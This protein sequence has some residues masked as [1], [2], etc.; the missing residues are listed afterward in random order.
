[1]YFIVNIMS[2]CNIKRSVVTDGQESAGIFTII[3]NT[4][5]MSNLKLVD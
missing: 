3:E 5:L 4:N 2:E 1:M